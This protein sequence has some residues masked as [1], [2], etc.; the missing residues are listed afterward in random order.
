V[1][2]TAKNGRELIEAISK[3][4]LPEIILLDISMPEMDGFETLEIIKKRFKNI[5]IIML[6][7]HNEYTAIFRAVSSGANGYISKNAELSEIITAIDQIAETGEYYPDIISD[8]LNDMS[9]YDLHRIIK[10]IKPKEFIFLKYACT[11]MSYKEIAA[12]MH[13]GRFTID[14]YRNALY[15]KLKVDSRIG[16]MLFALKYKLVDTEL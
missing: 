5:K 8:Q 1:Y 9:N 13:V 15:E 14:D 12:K 7:I 10:T 3:T 6:T 2:I 11:G 16:L 4:T